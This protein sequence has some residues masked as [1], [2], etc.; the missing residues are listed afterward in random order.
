MTVNVSNDSEKHMKSFI[1]DKELDFSLNKSLDNF[2]SSTFLLLE[3]MRKHVSMS[4][5]A[6]S[7]PQV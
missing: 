5:V 7:H 3:Y 4:H 1:S 2:N 6:V